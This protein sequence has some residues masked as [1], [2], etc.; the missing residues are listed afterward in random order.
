[1][2]LRRTGKEEFDCQ[3]HHRY[4]VHQYLELHRRMRYRLELHRLDS[5]RS[6]NSSPRRKIFFRSFVPS[7]NRSRGEWEDNTLRYKHSI[8]SSQAVSIDVG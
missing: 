6:L 7:R 8:I 5:S 3:R 2:P 4:R 1:M